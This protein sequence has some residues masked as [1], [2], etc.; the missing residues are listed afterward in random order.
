[1]GH[2]VNVRISLFKFSKVH[3]QDVVGVEPQ[4]A[5]LRGEPTHEQDINNQDP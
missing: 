5:S 3:V 2:C 4:S 1:M